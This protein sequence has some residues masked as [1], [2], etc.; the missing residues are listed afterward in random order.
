VN[1]PELGAIFIVGAEAA[2]RSKA[3]LRLGP[4]RNGQSRG[5]RF[6]A[7]HTFERWSESLLLAA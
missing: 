6:A 7:D 5:I 2:Y 3:S 1:V 4:A